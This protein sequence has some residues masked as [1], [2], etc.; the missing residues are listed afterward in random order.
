MA[1]L[2][3][4]GLIALPPSILAFGEFNEDEQLAP[5]PP[6]LSGDAELREIEGYDLIVLPPGHLTLY[7]R[8]R[9][10]PD[11]SELRNLFS[12]PDPDQT[13]RGRLET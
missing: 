5:L 2:A 3:A 13:Q 1:I 9:R 11:I 6:L 8:I 10:V 7:P 4:R 12:T